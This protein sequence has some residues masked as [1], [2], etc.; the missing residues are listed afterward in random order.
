M[1]ASDTYPDSQVNALD[2]LCVDAFIRDIAGARALGTALESGLIDY[3]RENRGGTS[4]EIRIRFRWDSRG[5]HLLLALLG[6]NHVVEE[7][8]GKINLTGQFMKKPH[9]IFSR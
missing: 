6:S 8:G 5:L 7:C 2:Y 3:L 4:E 1:P 9:R